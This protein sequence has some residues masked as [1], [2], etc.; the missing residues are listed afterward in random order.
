MSIELVELGQGNMGGD[1]VER[2]VRRLEMRRY[3]RSKLKEC[4]ITLSVIGAIGIASITVAV[5][6]VQTNPWDGGSY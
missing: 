4:I 3:N 2:D 6:M 5:Y 1:D